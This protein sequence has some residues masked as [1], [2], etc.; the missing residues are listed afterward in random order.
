M[1]NYCLAKFPNHHQ[2]LKEEIEKYCGSQNSPL[3]YKDLGNLTFLNAFMKEFLRI[4][5]PAAGVLPRE[6]VDEHF[7]Q[8]TKTVKGTAI[9][10]NLLGPMRNEKYFAD[11]DTFNP[12]RW[13]SDSNKD[14][15]NY[16]YIPFS[17][18]PRNCI[19][20]HLSTLESKLI[21]IKII[22]RYEIR[23]NTERQL[24]FRFTLLRSPA[25]GDLV[26]LRKIKN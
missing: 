21:L 4:F 12:E 20:Q 3:T 24:R 11:P 25:D 6:C 19:G 9:H 18:G 5:T 1:S 10:C 2:R 14:I 22:R 17:G 23:L 26:Y 15:N 8:G 7:F 16:S 13:L